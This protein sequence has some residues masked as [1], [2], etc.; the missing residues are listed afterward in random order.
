MSLDEYNSWSD[1]RVRHT[2]HE[3]QVRFSAL[4]MARCCTD[5]D[6]V[7]ELGGNF[8]AF[9]FKPHGVPIREGQRIVLESL[10]KGMPPYG[11]VYGLAQGEFRGET[12]EVSRWYAIWKTGEGLL[13]FAEGFDF[14]SFKR[15]HTLWCRAAYETKTT[16]DKQPL[17][18][19]LD[20]YED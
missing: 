2:L 9:E 14:P 16:K 3:G 15:L 8:F 7:S 12:W 17:I 18:D 10:A 4:P 19:L 5:I 20:N 1:G 13:G 6:L 11:V